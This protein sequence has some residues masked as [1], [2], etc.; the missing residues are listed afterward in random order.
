MNFELDPMVS[1]FS[2]LRCANGLNRERAKFYGLND[3]ETIILIHIGFMDKPSQ[4]NIVEK[5]GAPKQTVNNIIKNLEKDGLIELIPDKTDKRFRILRLT[6]KGEKNRDERLKPINE[7]NK[8]MYDKL[9]DEKA[10]EIKNA[11][12]LL[13]DSIK[14]DFKKEDEWKV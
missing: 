4:K 9:G 1:I 12:K 7:S 3:L 2:L 11:L 14:E 10:K 6:E 13:I 8:R 5:L